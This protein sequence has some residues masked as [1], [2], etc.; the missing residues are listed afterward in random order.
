MEFD[1]VKAFADYGL[2]YGGFI[3]LFLWQ[4]RT[5]QSREDRLLKIV[6]AQSATLE[7]INQTQKDLKEDICTIKQTIGE[8]KDR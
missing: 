2:A 1:M 3:F 8:L 5:S 4:V 6:E 7:K